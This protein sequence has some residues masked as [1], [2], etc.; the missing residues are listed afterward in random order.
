MYVRYTFDTCC[1]Q[2]QIPG[3]LTNQPTYVPKLFQ[4]GS[5][6]LPKMH[7]E[8]SLGPSPKPDPKK[9][10]NLLSKWCP[11]GAQNDP[12]NLPREL[13]ASL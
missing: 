13:L 6:K 3:A 12:Q 8:A 7:P 5:Q 4:N 2:E 10:L 1:M 11:K 9:G